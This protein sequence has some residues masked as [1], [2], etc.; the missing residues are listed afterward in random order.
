[1]PSPG[2]T[3]DVADK[4]KFSNKTTNLIFYEINYFSLVAINLVLRHIRVVSIVSLVLVS[5]TESFAA[6][7]VL[8]VA[9][10]HGL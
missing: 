1:M 6:V 3:K 10:A 2:S 8:D 9:V 4:L 5:E 7:A